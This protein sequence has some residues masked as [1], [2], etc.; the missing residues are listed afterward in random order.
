[1]ILIST[2]DM[3]QLK[4]ISIN[5]KKK[6]IWWKEASVNSKDGGEKQLHV[7]TVGIEATTL[8]NS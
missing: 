2:R 7:S 4:R 1:M 5:P 3:Q 8:L 6:D